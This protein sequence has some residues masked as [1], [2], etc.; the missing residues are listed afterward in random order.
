MYKPRDNGNKAD[1][2]DSAVGIEA[3]VIE[4]KNEGAPPSMGSIELEDVNQDEEI[5][6]DAQW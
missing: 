2:W 5:E 4:H 6:K 1:D 3:N